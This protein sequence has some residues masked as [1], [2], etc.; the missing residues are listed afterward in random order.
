MP[1]RCT[2]L[3]TVNGE[4]MM[5]RD[6]DLVTPLYVAVIV[7]TPEADT[8]VITENMARLA[9]CG[10]VA[11]A[12]TTAPVL[13][14]DNRM[15]RLPPVLDMPITHAVLDPA[16]TD[17]KGH[18]RET[19]L[20]LDQS[21]SLAVADEAPSVAVRVAVVSAAMLPATTINVP[22]EFPERIVVAPCN[23]TSEVE[24]LRVTLVLPA[25]ASVRV[26]VHT[27]PAPDINPA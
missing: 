1:V 18:E 15:L 6:T 25:A 2:E 17:D 7:A 14:L 16:V 22:A 3:F 5:D 10:T 9:L 8:A 26:T 24:E 23:K 19:R 13:L 11:I 12:G 20:G 21:V 27:A 4:G